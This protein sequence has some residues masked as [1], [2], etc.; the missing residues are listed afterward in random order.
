MK[1]FAFPLDRVLDWR[2]TQ[3]GIEEANLG[4]LHAELRSL[5]ARQTA[6]IQ[7]F[8]RQR[9]T[10]IRAESHTGFELT[11]FDEYRK[12]V[13]IDWARLE[14]ARAQCGTRIA[15]QIEAVRAKRRDLRLLERLRDRRF[16][17]W[18]AEL[19]R[20]VDREAADAYLARR[21]NRA[22]VSL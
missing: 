2:R 1:K 13:V 3:A 17:E 10:L 9:D 4:R 20:E 16:A 7:E 19:G 15:A 14:Q 21:Q 11:I 12:S 5:E 18:T 22:P 6:L 8:D